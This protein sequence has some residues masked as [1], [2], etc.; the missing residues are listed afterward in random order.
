LVGDDLLLFRRGVRLRRHW[1]NYIEIQA[2]Q[3]DQK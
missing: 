3:H 2:G 1:T